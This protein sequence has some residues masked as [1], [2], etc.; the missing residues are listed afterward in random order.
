MGTFTVI[1]LSSAAVYFA[2]LLFRRLFALAAE[3]ELRKSRYVRLSRE[4][5][6][7]FARGESLE[8]LLRAAL[9]LPCGKVT[10]YVSR[11]DEESSYIAEAMQKY[12]DFEIRYTN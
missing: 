11:E 7:I 9:F 3:S 1:F 4:G 8:Y 10:V 12:Y 6:E 2:Y 5:A